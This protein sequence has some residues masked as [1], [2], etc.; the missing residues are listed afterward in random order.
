MP[1]YAKKKVEL[2]VALP[3]WEV[4]LPGGSE[5]SHNDVLALIGVGDELMVAAVKAKSR[6][7]STGPSMNGSPTRAPGKGNACDTSAVCW[8]WLSRPL[9]ICATSCSIGR[10]LRSS[11]VGRFRAQ[12]AAM[13]VHS[14]SAENAG[15][16]DYKAFVSGLGGS[17]E[18]DGDD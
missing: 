14:F 18:P 13:V 8:A 11:S 16:D 6:S 7:R 4:P 1:R 12:A 10:L 15:F 9:G 17:A 3:E 5:G 2:L